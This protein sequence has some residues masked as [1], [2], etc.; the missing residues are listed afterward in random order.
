M[1]KEY[2][3]EG[4]LDDCLEYIIK[5]VGKATSYPNAGIRI[6]HYILPLLEK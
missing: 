6:E 3:K 2:E 4:I 5:V 1:V